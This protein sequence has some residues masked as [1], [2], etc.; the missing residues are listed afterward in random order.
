MFG[1]YKLC[2]SAAMIVSRQVDAPRIK[3]FEQLDEHR[4]LSRQAQP[5]NRRLELSEM[6][7]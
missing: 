7:S 2:D 1:G 5:G 3:S 4:R 6:S